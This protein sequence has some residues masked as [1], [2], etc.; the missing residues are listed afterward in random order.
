MEHVGYNQGMVYGTVHTKAFNHGIGIQKGDSIVVADAH[1]DFHV[2]AIDWSPE[3]I[4]FMVDGEIY[5]TFSNEGTG[6]EAWPL[7]ATGEAPGVWMKASGPSAWKS[8][9]CGYMN[10]V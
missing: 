1:N 3:K 5:N 7:V 8:T 4:D 9:M 6:S 2:Y 10:S